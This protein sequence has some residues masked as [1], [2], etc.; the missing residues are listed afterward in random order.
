MIAQICTPEA[1]DRLGR[2]ALVKASRAANLENRLI[3][4]ARSQQ[5]RQR[6]TDDDLLK[7]I[8]MV[9]EG[10]KKASGSSDGEIV[11]QRRRAAFDEEDDDF[12]D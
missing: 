2:I 8:D 1:V 5:L 3:M 4:L 6:V 7:L 12:F 11:F 10:S 9:D